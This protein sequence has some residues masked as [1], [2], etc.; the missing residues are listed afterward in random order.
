MKI[1]VTRRINA[2]AAE[3]WPHLA[4]YGNVNKFHPFLKGSDY[5][6]ETTEG[7]L[8]ATRQCDFKDGNTIKEKVI[9][10]NEGSSYTVEMFDSSLPIKSGKGTLGL[11]K[12]NEY[13]TEVYM[14]LEADP[15][16]KLMQPMMY[17]QFK[18]VMVPKILKSLEDYH[19][20]SVGIAAA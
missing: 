18:Y 15:K 19:F 1:K 7:G 14:I 8:G 5:T 11:N 20:R 4:D 17:M 10:W 3:L 9:E 16:N 12:I 6:G 13:E 2:T